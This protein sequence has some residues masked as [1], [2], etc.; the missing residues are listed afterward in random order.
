MPRAGRKSTAAETPNRT[1]DTQTRDYRYANSKRKNNPPAG[2]AAQGRLAE[3][4]KEKFSY[5]PHLPPALRFAPD[6]R[7]DALPDLLAE[8]RNRALTADEVNLLAEALRTQEPWLEWTGKREKRELEVDAQP[9][10]IH[11]RVAAKAI[12]AVAARQ[13][14]QRSFFADPQQEYREAVKFYQHDVEWSNRLILGD[15]L[16]VMSSLARREDLAG[17][18]QM[19]YVDP[20]YGI[21]FASNFQPQVSQ[22]N[23]ADKPADLTRE[24]EVVKAYR[25]TWTLGTHSYLTYLQDR[26][27]VGKDLLADS[28]SIFVQIGD[29]NLHRV[30]CLLDAI[31]GPQNLV[32]FITFKK[33]TTATSDVIAPV[34]DYILW[35][36]KSRE[37]LRHR[38]LYVAKRSLNESR[39]GYSHVQLPS[40]Q[41]RSL[42]SSETSNSSSLD[43]GALVFRPDNLVS[44]HFWEEGSKPFSFHGRSFSPGRNCWKTTLAGLERLGMAERLMP[45]D[46][47]VRFIRLMD[48][49]SVSPISNLWDD[50][51]LSGSQDK[52]YVVQT[53]MK[54][55]ERCLLMATDPGDLVLDPTCGSGTTAY[56][57]EQW[58]RRWITIDTS[59][60]ALAIARQRLLTASFEYYRLRDETAGPSSSF[61][62]KAVSH[63]QLRSIAQNTAL[64]PIFARHAP[65]L[66]EK[67]AALNRELAAV[68]DGVRTKLLSK[69]VAKERA[70]GKKS[71]TDADRR[72]W[73]LPRKPWQEWE[74][75]FD[76]DPEWPRPLQNALA[77]Y[78]SAWRAKMDEVNACI[79]ASAET[80]ELVD[81]PEVKRG[82]TRVSGPFTVEAVLPPEER[83]DAEPSP[84]DE[85]DSDLDSFDGDGRVDGG[86]ASLNAA[87]YLEQMLTYLRADGV[88]FPDNKVARF[89]RLEPLEGDILHAEGEWESGD[90]PARRVAV[91]VGPQYGPITA[92]LVEDCLRIAYRRGY[93]DLVFAGFSFDAAAQAI[94]QDDPN[95]RVHAHLAHIRPDVSLG[96]LLKETPNSQLFTVFGLPRTRLDPAPEGQWQVTME[97]VDVYD[98]VANTV[99]STGA[100]KVAA[101]FLD[102]DYDGR[103]FCICQAFFPD[104]SAWDKLAR[105][106][107]GVIDED[108][109]AQ[110]A[111]TVSLPFPAGKHG[112]V[113]V[114]VIDPRGN[115]VLRVHTLTAEKTYA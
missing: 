108:A 75:P 21:R 10:H 67:L 59:R 107:K 46:T 16:V 110:F 105:A 84:I 90:G 1:E 103:T 55:I 95:P 99:A 50:T 33:T 74:V 22:R 8:A 85:P 113:A 91:A 36:A 82:V 9:L 6:G 92:R 29:E 27:V 102:S 71:I 25:D 114:K 77:A 18:V 13:E 96:N 20:P 42:T 12:L 112:K 3:R 88:R 57:A 73:Q 65:I 111:G 101:W 35:Y 56:V 37:L 115:E 98:P 14:V 72:R 81:Q 5:N 86:V 11:E 104:R 15:S 100:T 38:P 17:K 69:L 30:R 47:S 31:F 32:G 41:R 2:L 39:A 63:I 51:S 52:V 70:E 53:N 80:E 78:R 60:V 43:E 44:S 34:S 83:L 76:A 45:M 62:Y 49:F 66:A 4:P 94:I 87:A 97:G 28:G 89:T 40:G 48:D 7:P 19:I 23:V 109:F 106:L 93:D 26:L 61:I 24:P 64:D 58:G 54:V 68:S 79:A